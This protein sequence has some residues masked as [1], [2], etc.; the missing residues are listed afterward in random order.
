MEW[1]FSF[2]TT[3][4]AIA[5]ALGYIVGS[6]NKSSS[7]SP[8]SLHDARLEGQREVRDY[9]VAFLKKQPKTFHKDA[10]LK[11][12]GVD[13]S[14]ANQQQVAAVTSAMA[15]NMAVLSPPKTKEERDLEN[16][17]L[18][19][20]VA[21]FLLV[22]AA[23]LFIGTGVPDA[24]K[25]IGVWLVAIGFYSIGMVVHMLSERLKPAAVAFVGT[26]LAILPFAGLA[27]NAYVLHDPTQSWL[28]TSFVGVGAFLY[29]TV[30]L[31]SQVLAYFTL[32]FVFSLTTSSAASL[33]APLVWSFT[34]IIIVGSLLNLIAY[35]Q[36]K[37][38]PSVF[39]QPID[40]SA[41]LSVPLAVFGSW[42][43]A[44][45]LPIWQHGLI[46]AVTALHYTLSAMRPSQESYRQPYIFVARSAITGAL[47]CFTY[48]VF[49]TWSAVGVTLVVTATV[50]AIA[51]AYYLRKSTVS[52]QVAWVWIAFVLQLFS[53]TFW[54]GGEK[55]WSLIVAVILTASL[56]TQLSIS[57]Y[58]R[59]A[60]YAA[61][62]I[63]VFAVLILH[64]TTSLIKP[65]IDGG[66]VALIFAL[67][68]LAALFVRAMWC[69]SGEK[70]E[71]A[72]GA[73]VLYGSISLIYTI[74]SGDTTAGWDLVLLLILS[75]VAMAAS[76]VEKV[77]NFLFLAYTL[78][79][80]AVW[81]GI[82]AMGDMMLPEVL[83]T[84]WM[85]AAF[86]YSTRIYYGY[87]GDKRRAGISMGFGVGV[88]LLFG[89]AYIFDT[90][91][92]MTAALTLIVSALI[93]YCESL[94]S[95]QYVVREIA[96]VIATLA[97]QRIIATYMDVDALIYTH[98][99]A[100]VLLVIAI[101]RYYR[102]EKDTATNIAIAGLC[103][104]S[105]P[106]GVAALGDP[107]TYQLLFLIE[108]VI[109]L[110]IG[111]AMGFRMATIWGAVGIA[112]ALLYLLQGF[113]SLLVGLIGIG[114]IVF[115]I[116]KLL[117]RAK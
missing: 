6:R 85:S 55:N 97:L 73:S 107:G 109:V 19:L 92:T 45:E 103:V 63:F 110:L 30:R 88:L 49:N 62:S 78:L 33:Q 23:V 70:L 59:R 90:T 72:A 11:E 53:I 48:S 12:M 35:K 87:I 105:L 43:V 22:A 113:T 16:I 106:T 89:L 75:A 34:L 57:Y 18:V 111:A 65:P 13:E 76:Y 93:L 32:A 10:L 9:I 41:Q 116:V 83:I 15:P 7:V 67:G 99:W 82:A 81:S 100:A 39:A 37:T 108:H 27:T 61:M 21:S 69:R 98:W 117:S 68:S 102:K 60:R 46:L 71:V 52:Y 29:A 14:H 115:A 80:F 36:P 77:E 58:L 74:I 96:L 64:I 91:F 20:Y 3:L 104:L 38:L 95:K 31:Q 25:F 114:L 94:I 42:L 86:Y 1:I 40:T 17:N 79:F 101:A 8:D 24:L 84:A 50:Q 28:I 44:N 4:L 2:G 5:F 66:Y 51:S 56:V 47:C 26:G 112:L 54:A